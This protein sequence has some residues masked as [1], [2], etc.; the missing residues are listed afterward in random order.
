MASRLASVP[1]NEYVNDAPSGSLTETPPIDVWFSAAEK[2]ADEL[3]D[4]ASFTLVTL[5]VTPCVVELVPSD[6]VTVA[7]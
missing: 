2:V 1:L 3:K 6:A 5:M 7:E 4:G